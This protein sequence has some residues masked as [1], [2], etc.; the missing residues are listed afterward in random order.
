M[1]SIPLR[2]RIIA[3]LIGLALGTTLILALL[4]QHFLALS[5][6][7]KTNVNVE[8][9]SAL[10]S[11]LSLAKENYDA[12]KT[13]TSGHWTA[14]IC[15]ASPRPQYLTRRV[16]RCRPRQPDPTY[17]AY[18][19]DQHRPLARSRSLQSRNRPAPTRTRTARLATR[20]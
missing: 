13:A 8:M 18:R 10:T 9:G 3:A 1:R 19:T 14:F 2:W 15:T 16:C 5:L 6:Q 4:A 17:F 12:K 7:T 20:H 11:A